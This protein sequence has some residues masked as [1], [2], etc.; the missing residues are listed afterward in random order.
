MQSTPVSRIPALGRYHAAHAGFPFRARHWISA[1]GNPAAYT[2]RTSAFREAWQAEEPR[3]W[4]SIHVA[5][6]GV[7][8]HEAMVRLVPW[9]TGRSR[10]GKLFYFEHPHLDPRKKEKNANKMLKQRHIDSNALSQVLLAT[11]IGHSIG[12]SRDTLGWALQGHFGVGTPG[13]LW[14]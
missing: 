4:R 5:V 10:P 14:G 1:Q 3:P 12:H 9:C 6:V 11:G 8:A 7:H 13:T 2:E